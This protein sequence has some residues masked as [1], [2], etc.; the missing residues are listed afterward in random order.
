MSLVSIISFIFMAFLFGMA[1]G[2]IAA[3]HALKNFPT[4]DDVERIRRALADVEM[5]IKRRR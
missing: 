5:M 1:G 2:Y 3:I 4:K